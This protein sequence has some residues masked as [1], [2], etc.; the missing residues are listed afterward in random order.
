MPAFD[1]PLDELET[2]DPALPEPE[3]LD[4]FWASTLAESRSAATA[5]T[6]SPVDTGL[7]GAQTYDV[8]F[9]GYGGD[10]VAAWLH[11]PAGA[12]GALPVVVQYVGYGGGRGLPHEAG[13]WVLSGRAHLVVDTRGQGSGWT[14]GSTPDPH[15]AGPASPGFLT[16]GLLDP[17]DYYYRRVYTDAVLAIDALADLPGVDASRVAVTG[18]SQGGGIALAVAALRDGLSAVMPDVPFLC[19]FRRAISLVMTDPYAELTR[20]LKAHRDHVSQAFTTLSYFDGAVLAR[21]AQ[22][23]ALFSVALMDEICPPSTV[24]AAYNAYAGPKE[25]RVYP[26]NDHEGGR[27]FQVG[28]QL[29]WLA[30]RLTSRPLD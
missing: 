20:Y 18:V 12:R 5:P 10:P 15:G 6:C 21:R 26:Y 8:S 19:H 14:V 28:E 1:L 9:S 2:F 24:Y 27:E 7:V 16:R 23:P 25:I 4:A 30:S 11:L 22:A 17:R 3:D 29:S 13:T